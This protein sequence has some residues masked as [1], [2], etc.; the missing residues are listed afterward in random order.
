MA[1]YPRKDKNWTVEPLGSHPTIYG[2][3]GDIVAIVYGNLADGIDAFD[4]ADRIAALPELLETLQE[5]IP[6]FNTARMLMDSQ[7]ARDL[8]GKLVEKGRAALAKA[9]GTPGL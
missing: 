8:A 6:A 4:R 5:L 1:E 9:Y 2:A 3:D 7:E